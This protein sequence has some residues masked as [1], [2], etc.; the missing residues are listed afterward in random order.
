MRYGQVGKAIAF[1]AIIVGSSPAT[2]I[3]YYGWLAESGW[4][5]VPAK[6]AMDV[7]FIQRFKS[8]IIRLC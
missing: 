5:H 7:K 1:G 4:L 6:E 3:C 8:S 2:A